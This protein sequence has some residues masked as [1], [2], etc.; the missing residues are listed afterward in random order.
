MPSTANFFLSLV[1]ISFK[2]IK[3][4]FVAQMIDEQ[5]GLEA[6]TEDD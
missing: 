5:P 6:T 4:V 3:K 2:T 1:G